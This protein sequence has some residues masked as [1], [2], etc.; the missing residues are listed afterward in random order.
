MRAPGPWVAFKRLSVSSVDSWFRLLSH[1]IYFITKWILDI[2]EKIWKTP[3]FILGY[4]YDGD[5]SRCWWV[6]KLITFLL[7]L[8]N[9]WRFCMYWI[10]YLQRVFTWVDKEKKTYFNLFW[11]RIN[12]VR[13]FVLMS[14]VA[15]QCAIICSLK[16]SS[17]K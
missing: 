13:F 10:K 15:V 12:L 16:G 2:S 3:Y 6:L 17:F 5:Q 4:Y 11:S 14:R 7:I 9:R 8:N 1:N